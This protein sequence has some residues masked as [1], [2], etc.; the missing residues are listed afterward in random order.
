[1]IISLP[2]R[3]QIVNGAS[4]SSAGFHLL[5]LLVSLPLAGVSSGA[6]VSKMKVAPLYVLLGG[7]ALQ[8]VGIALMGFLPSSEGPVT[9]VQYCSEFI[10]GFGF[11]FNSSTLIILLPLVIEK[12]D[13]G[14][15]HFLAKCG[16]SD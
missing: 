14:L 12:Q 4:P 9:P 15:R 3:F 2:Q 8:I 11:G 13:T 7:G 5:P 1:M 6:L 10:T 16:I